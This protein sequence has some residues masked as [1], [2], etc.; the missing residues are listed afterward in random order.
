MADDAER[1]IGR[2][3]GQV[4]AL[5]AQVGGLEA[6]VDELVEAF[7]QVKG[8]GR[9]LISAAAAAGAAAGMLGP[10]ISKKLGMS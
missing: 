6:K 10:W 9:V 8:G 5:T 2:L 1:A 4:T 7:H 3:E